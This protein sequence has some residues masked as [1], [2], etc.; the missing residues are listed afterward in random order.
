MHPSAYIIIKIIRVHSTYNPKAFEIEQNIAVTV[1][2]PEPGDTKAVKAAILGSW[3]GKDDWGATIK[4]TFKD[5][6]TVTGSRTGSTGGTRKFVICGPDIYWEAK[7]GAKLFVTLTNDIDSLDGKW[8][9]SS[10]SGNFTLK[11]KQK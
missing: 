8:N 7:S 11:R 3:Q 5:N 2:C 4:A 6:N 9:Y 1:D 10:Y